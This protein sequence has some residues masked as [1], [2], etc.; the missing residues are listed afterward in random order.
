MMDSFFPSLSG[1]FLWITWSCEAE[2]FHMCEK[3]ISYRQRWQKCEE[4]WKG[5]HGWS[6][7]HHWPYACC[8]R[9][10]LGTTWNTEKNYINWATHTYRRCSPVKDTV[11]AHRTYVDILKGYHC[12]TLWKAIGYTLIL[13]ISFS[14]KVDTFVLLSE[15][16]NIPGT[17]WQRDTIWISLTTYWSSD[18]VS[19]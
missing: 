7:T 13:T 11:L 14:K 10:K 19:L 1:L 17:A 9:L 18:E 6:T 2:V 3:S 4:T 8:L 15:I 5:I 16:N 12:S